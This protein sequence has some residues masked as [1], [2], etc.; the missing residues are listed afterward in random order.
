MLCSSLYLDAEL[1]IYCLW[2]Q[3]PAEDLPHA[4]TYKAFDLTLKNDSI[5]IVFD[6][7]ETDVF[8][9]A[10]KIFCVWRQCVVMDDPFPQLFLMAKGAVTVT[11]PSNCT[12]LFL[13]H[14][15]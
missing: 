8:T 4:N 2:S 12:A 5:T 13:G 11:V 1:S 7:E 3:P 6:K 15:A 10:V 9:Q 14:L